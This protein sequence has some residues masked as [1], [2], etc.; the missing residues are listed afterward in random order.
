MPRFPNNSD[1]RDLVWS[2]GFWIFNTYSR[3]PPCRWSVD[4]SPLRNSALGQEVSVEGAGLHPS[5]TLLSALQVAPMEESVLRWHL[6]GVSREMG[7][8]SV[9]WRGGWAG[10][11]AGGLPQLG[12]TFPRLCSLRQ[13]SGSKWSGH[14]FLSWLHVSPHSSPEPSIRLFS[15]V[16]EFNFQ[17]VKI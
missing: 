11:N 17:L 3:R 9:S 8:V 7:H 4:K 6:W 12:P 10:R 14:A 13:A 2:L 16:M 1:S 15:L 5:S